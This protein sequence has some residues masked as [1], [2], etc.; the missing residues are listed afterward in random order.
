MEAIAGKAPEKPR[1]ERG[2]G[3]VYQIGAIWWVGFYSRGKRVRESSGS[4]DEA[5]ARRLLRRRLKEVAAGS[6]EP[7]ADRLTYNDLRAAYISDHKLQRATDGEAKLLAPV[8]RLDRFFSGLRV[9][10]ITTKAMKDFAALLQSEGLA[11][12]SI[13]RSLS[14]LRRMFNL[15]KEEERLR[16]LPYFPM[17]EEAA[18]RKGF[19]ERDEYERLHAALP[20]YLRPVVAIGFHTGMRRAEI[21]GLRWDQV[22]LLNRVIRLNAGETKNGEAR[23]IPITAELY[24]LL[25]ALPG[26]R[27]GALVCSR[28]TKA[29]KVLPVGDFRKIW[30]ARCVKLGLGE[31]KEELDTA[32]GE[33][34]V[35]YV[36]KVFHDLRRTGVRN[37]VRA[38]V[39]EK[40]AMGITGHK[41]R[42]VF[43]R[44]NIVSERDLAEAGAK[45]DAYNS[46]KN[47]L[48]LVQVAPET[49]PV[50]GKIN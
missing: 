37:L 1:R 49:A 19:F 17:L 21:T 35:V 2:S 9:S 28:S 22:D 5:D 18:P 11:N 33:T 46:E 42:S 10:E 32:T 27:V 26:K 41:T 36:G 15:A 13:N 30:Y 7:E 38:G 34:N 12:G 44:Y 23:N 31:M 39:P 20:D 14:A 45:L 40:I 25:A 48:S 4:K 6:H 47:G 16:F 24:A 43:D 8:A 50:E 29:G 3:S